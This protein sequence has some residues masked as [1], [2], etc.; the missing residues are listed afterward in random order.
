MNGTGTP[1]DSAKMIQ[2]NDFTANGFVANHDQI[3]L[4]IDNQSKFHIKAKKKKSRAEFK[5]QVMKN[6]FDK[7]Y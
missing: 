3:N 6:H 5:S 2:S 4:S 7:V 1:L